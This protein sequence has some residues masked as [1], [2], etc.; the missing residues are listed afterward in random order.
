MNIKRYIPGLSEFPVVIMVVGLASVSAY[1]LVN[2]Q[3]EAAWFWG[4]LAVL[5]LLGG[6]DEDEKHRGTKDAD[7]QNH[8]DKEPVGHAK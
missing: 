6:D 2:K 8:E 7:A 5:P 1:C 4:I 3:V